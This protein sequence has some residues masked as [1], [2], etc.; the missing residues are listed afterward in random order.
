MRKWI[1]KREDLGA[2]SNLLQE[3]CQD[4]AQAYRNILRMTNEKFKELLNMV[5]PFISKND[6][7]M[8]K[9]LSPRVK[10]EITLR[11]L[12]TGDSFKSLEYLFRVPACSISS[13]LPDVLEAITMVLKPF[14]KVCNE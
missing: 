2:S 12:A 14:L 7:N 1:A 6:T 13:F 3:L 5:E 11:F 9:A 4:D 10:L 8:R